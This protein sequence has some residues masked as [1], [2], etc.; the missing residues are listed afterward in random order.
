MLRLTE[1]L[2]F[3]LAV[4]RIK[5]AWIWLRELGGEYAIQWRGALLEHIDFAPSFTMK[6]QWFSLYIGSGHPFGIIIQRR[7]LRLLLVFWH[8][9]IRWNFWRAI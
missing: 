4:Q 2:I 9:R 6:G 1:C 3:L 5:A 8:A 7:Y